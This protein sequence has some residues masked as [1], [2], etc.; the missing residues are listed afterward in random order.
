MECTMELRAS[1]SVEEG[2][3]TGTTRSE[4]RSTS[5]TN[6]DTTR[7]ESTTEWGVAAAFEA[8]IK[9]TGEGN[10]IFTKATIEAEFRMRVIS[11]I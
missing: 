7:D 4:T 8:A 9:T 10:L 6:S 2:K 5:D 11:I 1:Q 3:E